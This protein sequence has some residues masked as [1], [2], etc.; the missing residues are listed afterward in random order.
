MGVLYISW[1]QLETRH[2]LAVCLSPL[3]FWL[4]KRRHLVTCHPL[5]PPFYLTPPPLYA[6]PH[7][8]SLQLPWG[9]PLIWRSWVWQLIL[10]SN[11][12]HVPFRLSDRTLLSRV[13]DFVIWQKYVEF[14]AEAGL[15]V[16][17]WI[18]AISWHGGRYKQPVQ[19]GRESAHKSWAPGDHP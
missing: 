18:W 5:S 2:Y 6:L 14:K 9:W 19:Y 3:S 7:L 13:K 1:V 4:D 8:D 16:A 15:L 12:D 17:A 11:S 10:D